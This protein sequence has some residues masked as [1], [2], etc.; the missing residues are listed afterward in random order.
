MNNYEKA[1]K[2]I[3]NYN[4]CNKGCTIYGVTNIN[5]NMPAVNGA[6]N[7]YEDLIKRHPSGTKGEAYLVDENIYIWDNE[8]G[9][10]VDAGR[11]GG[12]KGDKGEKGEK[13]DK[14]DKG[15]VGAAGPEKLKSA[16][17]VSFNKNRDDGGDPV[18]SEEALPLERVELN[19]YD[20]VSVDMVLNRLKFNLVG[21]YKI[22]FT[23]SAYVRKDNFDTS[24]DIISAGLRPINSD[25]IYIGYSKWNENDTS[26]IIVGQG[27]LVINDT[28]MEYELVNLS[29]KEIIL[30]SP[31]LMNLKTN[32]YY[33]NPTVTML[34]EYLGR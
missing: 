8:R 14:G 3:C 2:K 34:I 24:K 20:I 10:W 7:S 30:D 18:K 22:T 5:R 11:M 19:P 28:A 23:V 12:A 31:N 4:K 15:D 25:E 13:G 17:I 1:L 33:A 32:S 29:P 27:M 21:Y 9:T 16:Y 6:F 26:E